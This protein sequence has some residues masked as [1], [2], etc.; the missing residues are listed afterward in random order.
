[1][2]RFENTVIDDLE[3]DLLCIFCC[4]YLHNGLKEW[5]AYTADIDAT[6]DRLDRALASQEPY[7]IE[8]TV[9][10]DPTWA[11]YRNLL[12]ETNP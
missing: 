6:C 11:E 7:P 2:A 8:I 5:M 9:E 4:V 12:A 10:D 1:M 3:E